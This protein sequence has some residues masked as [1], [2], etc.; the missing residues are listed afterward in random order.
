[1]YTSRIEVDQQEVQKISPIYI[2]Q[3]KKHLIHFF[4]LTSGT[5][6]QI[7]VLNFIVYPFLSRRLSEQAFGEFLLIMTIINFYITTF[8]SALTMAFYREFKDIP[9]NMRP[10]I[11]GNTFNT[12]LIGFG[13]LIIANI[14]GYGFFTTFWRLS[15]HKLSY[16]YLLCYALFFIIDSLLLARV[17]FDF[18]FRIGFYSR[19]VFFTAS[20]FLIPAFIFFPN[21]WIAY[22]MLAPATSSIML[23]LCL[24]YEGKI[25]LKTLN[26]NSYTRKNISSYFSFLLSC[27]I[28]QTLVFSDRWVVAFLDIPKS[29]IAYLTIAIQA[30]SLIVFPV[31]RLADLMLPSTANI[32]HFRD[33]TKLKAKKSFIAVCGSILYVL[34][35]GMLI[36]FIFFKLYKPSYIEYGW[37]Y[38]N[39]L[40][41]GVSF[42]PFQILSRAYIVRFF[43]ISYTI[44]PQLIGASLQ[45]TL[46]IMLLPL[47]SGATG[48]AV[49]RSITGI[50]I[51]LI[52]F[53]ICQL[54]IFR[55]AFRKSVFVR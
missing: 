1:L 40:L 15:F 19:I 43:P 30:C 8:G 18:N 28:S 41:I 31:E 51:A 17:Y 24:K 21:Q 3:N 54:P 16:F 10:S 34:L 7:I 47:F 4:Y 38:F 55:V 29:E 12:I 14:L 6:L 37:K 48:A 13:L 42:I 50:F 39:L 22:F 35:F 32:E 45:I 23:L 5:I 25:T 52:Y 46:I 49:G 26:L 20:L 53:Y 2:K 36:G 44:I 33:I 11:M 9:E 27:L